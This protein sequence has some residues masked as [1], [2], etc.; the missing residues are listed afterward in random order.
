MDIRRFETIKGRIEQLQR[1]QTKAEGVLDQL[2][3][4]METKYG[5]KT[6]RH[7]EKLLLKMTEEADDADKQYQEA[8]SKFEK[9][10]GHLLKG[11]V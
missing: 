5:C 2:M 4:E 10:W 3:S 6:I 9:D 1:E 8:L 11:G 7:A